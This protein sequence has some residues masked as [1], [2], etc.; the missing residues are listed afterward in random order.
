MR[1]SFLGIGRVQQ[2]GGDGIEC[3]ERM[4]VVRDNVTAFLPFM[5]TAALLKGE[6]VH[7]G[8]KRFLP[9]ISSGKTTF[10]PDEILARVYEA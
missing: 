8:G 2:D 10:F 3:D 5:R 4:L 6:S 9:R 7:S 1:G